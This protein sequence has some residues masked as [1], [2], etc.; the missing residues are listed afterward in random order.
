MS[1][2]AVNVAFEKQGK[3]SIIR[4]S[5]PDGGELPFSHVLG[6]IVLAFQIL[7]QKNN[8]P[9]LEVQKFV[10]MF[11]YRETTEITPLRQS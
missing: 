1:I 2:V 7:C 4:L 10:D 11:L 9:E 6:G 5:S 8:V 3:D